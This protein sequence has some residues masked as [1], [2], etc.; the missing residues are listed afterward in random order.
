MIQDSEANYTEGQNEGRKRN[1]A[2]I[3]FVCI[4]VFSVTNYFARDNPQALQTHLMRE[5]GLGAKEYNQLYSFMS[6]P[7][8]VIP[9]VFGTLL[10]LFGVPRLNLI[11]TGMIVIGQFLC[12]YA[13]TVKSYGLL[14]IARMIYG[15]GNENSAILLQYV[16]SKHFDDKS[17][18]L[19]TGLS[20]SA[21]RLGNILN[22]NLTPRIYNATNSLPAAFLVPGI[23]LLF[24]FLAM[25][26][27]NILDQRI[28][29][30]KEE[31]GAL[32]VRDRSESSK[33][34]PFSLRRLSHF[35][36]GLWNCI[37]IGALLYSLYFGFT[38][39]GSN[40]IQEFYNMEYNQ[41]NDFLSII[42]YIA[43][44]AVPFFGFLV[45]KVGNRH[46]FFIAGGFLSIASISTFI[47]LEGTK[48]PYLVLIPLGLFSSF[49]CSM[50]SNIWSVIP[51][52]AREDLRG[53]ALGVFST[54]KNIGQVCTP[55]LVGAIKDGFGYQKVLFLFESI[56]VTILILSI[57]F[58]IFRKKN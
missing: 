25:F 47:F 38:N 9:L 55:M 5:L 45:D 50:A 8:I 34:E 3:L 43:L 19:Y 22:S 48:F 4:I 41:S 37:L 6:I 35:S 27:M 2:K 54:F 33:K 36:A 1:M 31:S 53:M 18:A 42:Y 28:T 32:L 11:V 12:V 46:L 13:A 56:S 7:S 23:G 44:F 39:I 21:C 24:G 20:I 52:Q 58:A 29:V 51:L 15:T 26:L 40:F 14:L 16:L 49:Y 57:I 10:D 17:I 30:L